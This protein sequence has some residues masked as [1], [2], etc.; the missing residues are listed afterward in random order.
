MFEGNLPKKAESRRQQGH[1]PEADP[2][3]EHLHEL[4][5]SDLRARF[6]AA[7]D[8]RAALD[9]TDLEAPA[10]FDAD[11]ARRIA[12][13]AEGKPLVNPDDL[14]NGKGSGDNKGSGIAGEWPGTRGS[15]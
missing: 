10:S 3:C 4:S 5:W 1:S 2:A 7:R 11:S 14:A 8:L 12:A 13:L 15:E 9:E 6:E